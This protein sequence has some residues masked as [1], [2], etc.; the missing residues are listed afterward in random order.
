V[1][2][3]GGV[4][5]H[6]GSHQGQQRMRVRRQGLYTDTFSLQVGDAAD[7]LASK[8]FEA[9]DH[10]AGHQRDRLASINRPD[11]V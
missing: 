1:D 2:I 8:Q 9:A 4:E 6:L 10:D 3:L 5:P 11:K 7:A